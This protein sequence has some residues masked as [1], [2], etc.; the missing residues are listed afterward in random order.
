MLLIR[1]LEGLGERRLSREGFG[2]LGTV[3]WVDDGVQVGF[4]YDS[5]PLGSLFRGESAVSDFFL[6]WVTVEAGSRL[7]DGT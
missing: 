2:G 4:C 3:T 6:Q 1:R 5:I 7:D